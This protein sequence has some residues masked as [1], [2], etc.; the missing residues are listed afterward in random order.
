MISWKISM[1]YVS[2]AEAS[3]HTYQLRTSVGLPSAPPF[4]FGKDI[5]QSTKI[6]FPCVPQE[7]NILKQ[8]IVHSDIAFLSPKVPN[9]KHNQK[10]MFATAKSCKL[11]VSFGEID[12]IYFS[13]ELDQ[14]RTRCYTTHQFFLP[15]GRL[16][17]MGCICRAPRYPWCWNLWKAWM[18]SKGGWSTN[19]PPS[20][21]KSPTMKE[22]SRNSLRVQAMCFWKVC[23]LKQA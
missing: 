6:A 19:P 15:K 21:R 7:N 5:Q 11:T 16:G 8:S 17:V 1:V 12:P 18:D 2:C 4:F 23:W 9:I 20:S 14:K 13:Q 3:V 22:K 10:Y